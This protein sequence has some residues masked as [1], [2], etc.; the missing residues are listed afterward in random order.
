V[1]F[2]GDVRQ[3][4]RITSPSFDVFVFIVTIVSR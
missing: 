4:M 2:E 3:E 1:L